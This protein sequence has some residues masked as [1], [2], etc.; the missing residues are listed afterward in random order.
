MS[1]VNIKRPKQYTLYALQLIDF[2][3][4]WGLKKKNKLKQDDH[5]ETEEQDEEEEEQIKK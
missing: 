4:I 2:I 1:F 5:D 3:F